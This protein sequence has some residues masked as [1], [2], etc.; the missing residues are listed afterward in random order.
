MK[1]ELD[2]INNQLC[3]NYLE[4]SKLDDGIVSSQMCA[5]VLSGKKDTCK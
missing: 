2:I 3:N 5:G 4:D 1:V